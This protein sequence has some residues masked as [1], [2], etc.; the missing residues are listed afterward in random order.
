MDAVGNF[1]FGLSYTLQDNVCRGLTAIGSGSYRGY[2]VNHPLRG[3]VRYAA[4]S[5][6]R[7]QIPRLFD[8]GLPAHDGSANRSER[9]QSEANH[10]HRAWFRNT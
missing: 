8:A 10:Q 7:R 9:N 4:A 1:G 5:L 3:G 6:R 2:P